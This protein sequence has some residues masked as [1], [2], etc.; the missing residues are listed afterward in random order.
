MCDER[1]TT[2]IHTPERGR[3][4]FQEYFVRYGHRDTMSA[5]EFAGIEKA[6][7]TPQVKRTI[8]EADFL[9]IGPS[10]PY[11]SIFPIWSVPG[12]RD[13]WQNSRAPKIAISPMIGNRAVKGP[14]AEMLIAQGLS[15]SPLGIARLYRSYIDALIIDTSDAPLVPTIRAIGVSAIPAP[16]TL[17][18]VDQRLELARWLRNFL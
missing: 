1:I 15:P 4:A 11:V 8:A 2:Y 18:T 13:L 5:W 10:N 17:K 3:L 12:L 7:L 9:I 6:R 14:L 16:I